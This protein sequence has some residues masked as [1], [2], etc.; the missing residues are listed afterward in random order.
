MNNQVKITSTPTPTPAILADLLARIE[1]LAT[2][3]RNCQ[4]PA[5]LP[6]YLKQMAHLI[7]Q[8][9]DYTLAPEA[10]ACLEEISEVMSTP[11]PEILRQSL[12]QL[13]PQARKEVLAGF[14]AECGGLSPCHCWNDE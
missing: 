5:A 11:K 14:C 13:T 9:G 12:E 10:I 1:V 8:A 6:E 4:T 3:A 7:R 2:G